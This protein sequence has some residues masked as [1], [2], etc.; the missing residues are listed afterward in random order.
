MGAT[1]GACTTLPKRNT[2]TP[3]AEL[4]HEVIAVI[5]ETNE[6][7]PSVSVG[8]VALMMVPGEYGMCE[9][10][11]APADYVVPLPGGC[12][13]EHLLMAQQLGT[14]LYSCKRLSNVVGQNAVVI[15]Q[16][17]AG[18]F[19]DT[20]LRRMAA[21][22]VIALDVKDAR[23]AAARKFG[24]THTI[25]N[26]RVSPQDRVMEILDGNL[27]DLVVE[28]VGEP[29]AINLAHTLVRMHGQLV[30][31]GIPRGPHRFEF[32]YSS[33]FNKYCDIITN[34]ST[35]NEPGLTS[36]RLAIKLI[37]DGQIDV[38]PM[39]T[40]R[41]PF[42]RVIEAYELART[43]DDGAVKIIVEMPGYASS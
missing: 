31:F 37:A 21:E 33:F 11:V 4:G 17:S 22:N 27:A 1:Y 10:F 39:I 19:W 34:S 30:Y 9:Y 35:I 40:H 6:T 15:G 32:D 43:R 8:D 26:A 3:L 2:P 38:S 23:L 5:E 16:G 20:M 25:N 18:L 24:A 36:F 42:E 29:D 41:F 14:V 12:P 7:G 13:L 28:A